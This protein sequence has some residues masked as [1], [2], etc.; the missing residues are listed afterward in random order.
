MSAMVTRPRTDIQIVQDLDQ[1][2]RIFAGRCLVLQCVQRDF[3]TNTTLRDR[4]RIEEKNSSMASRIIRD[5]IEAELIGVHD[6]TVGSRARK[7]LP[8][9]A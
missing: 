9:W 2:L 3:M 4:F 6:K 7:Y 5:T 1:C 8:W